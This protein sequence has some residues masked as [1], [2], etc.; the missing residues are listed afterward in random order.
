MA[1]TDRP[2]TGNHAGFGLKPAM[3]PEKAQQGTDCAGFVNPMRPHPLQKTGYLRV[4]ERLSLEII[5]LDHRRSSDNYLDTTASQNVRAVPSPL[6]P[7]PCLFRTI[8]SRG[9]IRR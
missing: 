3:E 1:K 2:P 7:R 4:R 8:R 9:R 6:V 5:P